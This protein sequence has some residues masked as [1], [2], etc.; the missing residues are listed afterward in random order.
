MLTADKRATPGWN[1]LNASMVSSYTPYSSGYVHKNKRSMHL[2]PGVAAHNHVD[3]TETALKHIREHVMKLRKLNS[4]SDITSGSSGSSSVVSG[5]SP[6]EMIADLVHHDN[7][8]N[9]QHQIDPWQDIST[10]LNLTVNTT[11]FNLT[12]N[13]SI[14]PF[15]GLV[16]E[17]LWTPSDMNEFCNNTLVH[18][19]CT[20]L[21]VSSMLFN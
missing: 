6:A 19:S 1:P 12:A 3:D 5:V 21:D 16:Q 20:S 8:A 11:D 4:T 14:G 18:N 15:T 9:N 10:D 2:N 17:G 7:A 13:T